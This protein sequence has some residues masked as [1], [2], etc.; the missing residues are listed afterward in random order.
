MSDTHEF[1][2]PRPVASLA[3]G[4]SHE[5]AA[6]V[7]PPNGP[8]SEYFPNV[9]VVTHEN[10]KALFYDDLLRGKTVLINFMSSND[11]MS[12]RFAENLRKVQQFIGP[13]LGRDVFIYSIT[14]D[15]QND[16][17]EKLERFAARHGARPG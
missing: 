12:F 10:R 9:L 5:Q 14:I 1:M 15:P 17:P 8:K 2:K 16:T 11:E 13:R 7:S 6:C 4:H 3:I